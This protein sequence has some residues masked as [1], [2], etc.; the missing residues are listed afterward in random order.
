MFPELHH[1]G[2]N[3]LCIFQVA[4]SLAIG[5]SKHL[6]QVVENKRKYELKYNL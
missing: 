2:I 5:I 4:Q 1:L 3:H 6:Y